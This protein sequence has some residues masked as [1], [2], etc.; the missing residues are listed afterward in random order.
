MSKL[1]ESSLALLRISSDSERLLMQ[2]NAPVALWSAIETTHLRGSSDENTQAYNIVRT[3]QSLRQDPNESIHRFFE[4]FTEL[5]N[6]MESYGAPTDPYYLQARHFLQSLDRSSMESF[7]PICTIWSSQMP[8]L[9][10]LLGIGH[11]QRV[12]PNATTSTDRFTNPVVFSTIGDAPRD[13][14]L[15]PSSDLEEGEENKTP[16]A[17]PQAPSRLTIGQPMRTPAM[18]M[19]L[20]TVIPFSQSPIRM[21]TTATPPRW[22]ATQHRVCPLDLLPCVSLGNNAGNRR[23][24]RTGFR[25]HR[26]LID[27]RRE[28]CTPSPPRPLLPTFNEVCGYDWSLYNCRRMH[29]DLERHREFL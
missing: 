9:G 26:R 1:S 20:D 27:I 17:G 24:T 5:T 11:L 3:Y 15:E 29:L 28:S 7:S 19:L 14:S 18:R 16:Q 10:T 8:F 21:S 4:R 13:R 2:A 23:R 22:Q 6:T 25:T 12:E